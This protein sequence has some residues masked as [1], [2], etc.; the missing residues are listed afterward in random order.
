MYLPRG[1]WTDVLLFKQYCEKYLV[2]TQRVPFDVQLLPTGEKDCFV[3]FK[4]VLLYNTIM[5]S[6]ASLTDWHMVLINLHVL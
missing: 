2:V 6:D 3:M 4:L 1:R 5:R